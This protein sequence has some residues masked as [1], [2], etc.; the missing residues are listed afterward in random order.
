MEPSSQHA[1]KKASRGAIYDCSQVAKIPVPS[2]HRI[3]GA[4][5]L[6]I[7]EIRRTNLR[8]LIAELA[9]GSSTRFANERGFSSPNVISQVAGPHPSRNI[10]PALA[11][12]IEQGAGVAHGWLDVNHA[13]PVDTSPVRGGQTERAIKVAQLLERLPAGARELAE[14]LIDTE[15][16]HRV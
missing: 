15:T 5:F 4:N 1:K 7:A 2:V 6:D 11:R 14:Q 13:A 8:K 3:D 12:R 10:G 9:D 16:I